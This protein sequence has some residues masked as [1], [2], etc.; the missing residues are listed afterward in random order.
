MNED[1]AS[2]LFAPARER[3]V[4]PA[5]FSMADVFAE[6]SRVRRRHRVSA[7]L[8]TVAVVLAV[9]IGSVVV[10]NG[11]GTNGEAHPSA[12]TPAAP[13]PSLA[14]LIAGVSLPPD[15]KPVASLGPNNFGN[16]P[17]ADAAGYQQRVRYWTTKLA[18]A[19]ALKALRA[20]L[21]AG[22]TYVDEGHG[23]VGGLP[24]VTGSFR[25]AETARLY[26]PRL[27]LNAQAAANGSTELTTAA[28]EIVKPAKT[29]AETVGPGVTSVVGSYDGKQSVTVDG[30]A[31]QQLARDFN[32]LWVNEDP[33]SSCPP[34]ANRV[35]LTFRGPGKTQ[36]FD[37]ACGLISSATGGPPLLKSSPAFEADLRT[38]FADILPTPV[39]SSPPVQIAPTPTPPSLAAVLN[40]FPVPPGSSRISADAS[41]LSQGMTVGNDPSIIRRYAYWTSPL[42]R[43]ATVRW[44]EQHLPST[45]RPSFDITVG[46][47]ESDAML[48]GPVNPTEDGPNLVVSV[49]DR[50]TGSY[51]R[52]QAWADPLVP[53]SPTE[54]L[55][56]VSAV[57]LTTRD[58]VAPANLPPLQTVKLT[59]AQIQQLVTDL[60]AMPVHPGGSISCTAG[61]PEVIL[62]FITK[63]GERRFLYDR[64]CRSVTLL[65]SSVPGLAPSPAFYRDVAA[66]LATPTGPVRGTLIADISVS[67]HAA[68]GGHRFNAKG[69][70]TV[71][72]NGSP[73]ATG[74]V[75]DGHSLTLTEPP[76]TYDVSAATPGA[77][78]TAGTVTVVAGKQ[79]DVSILCRAT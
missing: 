1:E 76:G 52:V 38:Y 40:Q 22:M 32:A 13:A 20:H 55:T 67:D 30:A 41:G 72:R 36:T 29:A 58:E 10:S 56:G 34:S 6:D 28:W 8:G 44:L 16:S 2:A 45:W 46:D 50:P 19:A 64:N 18:P 68:R 12:T 42:P 5:A 21:P 63:A 49:I 25:A 27:L 47:N 71:K 70:I 33:P 62:D 75:A 54:T 3:P 39:P 53:K 51:I 77:A 17:Y 35:T 23:T 66:D 74:T 9:V 24:F 31:A 7:V 79:A 4:P 48:N 69:T 26:G 65:H 59:S 43:P 14:E 78:C 60:N 57:T 73:I 11:G 61:T 37:E 15:A